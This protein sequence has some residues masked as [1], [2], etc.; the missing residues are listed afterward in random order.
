MMETLGKFMV[1]IFT[2]LGVFCFTVFVVVHYIRHHTGILLLNISWIPIYRKQIC[3][4][5]VDRVCIL[6]LLQ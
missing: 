2:F 1:Y 4:D 6:F 5:L 3:E